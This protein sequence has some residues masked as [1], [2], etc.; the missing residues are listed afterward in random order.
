MSSNLTERVAWAIETIKADRD[1]DEGITD[2]KLA[3]IL[4]TNKDTLAAYRNKKGLLK[5][6]V[7]ERIVEHYHFNPM[8]LFHGEGE[9]FP[10]ARQK[11]PE[12]CG[13]PEQS[14]SPVPEPPTVPRTISAPS[15]ETGEISIGDDVTLAIQVLSSGTPYATALHLNI[16]SFADAVADRGRIAHVEQMQAEMEAK[17]RSF[18]ERMQSMMTAMKEEIAGLNSEI[19]TLREENAGLKAEIKVLREENTALKEEIGILRKENA[20]LKEKLTKSDWPAGA[21]GEGA[22]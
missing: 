18:E 12:V 13:P 2:I 1:L 14:G 10:G 3:K 16:R 19:V 15:A 7:I 22:A 4:G 17:S 6:E 20:Y 11:Y 5:G 21:A 8:W 9:P